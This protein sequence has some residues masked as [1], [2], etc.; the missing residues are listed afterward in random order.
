MKIILD[1]FLHTFD[2][3]G[4]TSREDA[5]IFGYI[6]GFFM[7]VAYLIDLHCQ[8]KFHIITMIYV[9]LL[10]LPSLSLAVRRLHDAGKSGWWLLL[11]IIVMLF[12]APFL[13][14][15]PNSVLI[16]P[17]IIIESIV[18]V[19][20]MYLYLLPSKNMVS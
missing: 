10:F 7:L 5:L 6:H 20:M 1:I 13:F 14:S 3:K 16:L 17:F 11:P 18:S 9:S 2:Y 15:N 19:F 8:N 4:K 12:F